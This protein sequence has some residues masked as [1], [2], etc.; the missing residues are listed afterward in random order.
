MSFDIASLLPLAPLHWTTIM[1]YLLILS[2]LVMLFVST[3]KSD[4]GFVITIMGLALVT[5][6]SLYLDRLH[7]QMLYIFLIRI[8]LATM[9][10]LL[11]GLGPNDKAR[12]LGLV[13]S[14][15]SLPL[16]AST[17]LGCMVTIL[18]DPRLAGWC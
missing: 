2:A 3:A 15:F 4:N 13:A 14:L 10:M 1:H 5:A 17:F 12:Q 11:A 6:A 16:L 9:T 18:M 7:L 8:G